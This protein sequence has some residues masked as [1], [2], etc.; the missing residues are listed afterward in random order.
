MFM[1]AISDAL[2]FGKRYG[3]T[4][5]YLVVNLHMWREVPYLYFC[6][7][8]LDR[9]CGDR[10]L[11]LV[12]NEMLL[13]RLLPNT[14][15]DSILVNA[16]ETSGGDGATSLRT[17]WALHEVKAGSGGFVPDAKVGSGG[18]ANY[19]IIAGTRSCR[20]C[21]GYVHHTAHWNIVIYEQSGHIVLFS[22]AF[23]PLAGSSLKSV[24]VEAVSRCWLA[25][26][27]SSSSCV[28]A[29]QRVVPETEACFE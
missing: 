6:V 21:I 1:S 2:P 12:S 17:A 16:F 24:F 8:G 19:Y 7:F 29:V 13:Y 3:C 14:G 4:V 11:A 28:C 15:Q 20:R 25:M 23:V 27:S 26:A 18:R 5:P 10:E 9:N 22:R